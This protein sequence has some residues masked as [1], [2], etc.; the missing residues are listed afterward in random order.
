M[1]PANRSIMRRPSIRYEGRVLAVGTDRGVAIWDLAHGA[2][3]AFL[4][5]GNAWHLMFDPAGDLITSGAMGVQRWPIHLN[6][7]RGEFRIGPPRRLPLPAGLCGIDQDQL[8]RIVATANQSYAHVATPE[9]TIR[10]GPLDDCRSVAV[11]PD[12]EWL[13]TNSFQAGGVQVWRIADATEV[14]KLPIDLGGSV[15][16]SPDGKWLMAGSPTRL[17]AVGTWREEQEIGGD[18]RCFSPDGRL[19]VVVDPSKAH[20]PGRDR[21]APHARTAGEP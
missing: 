19:V 13:A 11:S 20:S 15:H 1:R 21:D 3:L 10:V 9:R 16:F 5:I 17:W 18:G 8:G 7:G 6:P 2:E 14:A 12:G 4:P